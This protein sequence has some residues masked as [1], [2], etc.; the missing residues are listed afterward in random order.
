MTRWVLVC[1]QDTRPVVQ[2]KNMACPDNTYYSVV[3]LCDGGRVLDTS[4]GMCTA[5]PAIP[6]DSS[7]VAQFWSAAFALVITCYLI[8]RS[9]GA[10]INFLNSR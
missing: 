2:L 1:T 3:E 6:I 10:L 5:A 4:T 9:V 7:T 8:S